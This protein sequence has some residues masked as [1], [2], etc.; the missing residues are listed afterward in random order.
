MPGY[1]HILFPTDFSKQSKAFRPFVQLVAR[2]FQAKV[3]VLHA[4]PVPSGDYGDLAG[5]LPSLTDFTTLEEKMSSLIWE[6]FSSADAAGIPEV[7]REVAF[8]D[9]TVAIGD[10]ARRCHVDLIMMT[11]HGHGR[12][13]NLLV[14]SVASKVLH[15]SECPVWTA[16][17]AEDPVTLSHLG[18]KNI[19]AALDLAPDRM[20]VIRRSAELA[21]EFGAALRLVHAIPAAEHTPG[22]PG[23]EQFPD[24]LLRT[25]RDQ[26]DK[27]QREAGTS[28]QVLVAPGGVAQAIRDAALETKAD[29]VVL[30]RGVVH[31]A[32]G[33]LLSKSYE[34]IRLSPC[35]VLSL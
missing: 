1:R 13:R 29:L 4:V 2:Q 17:H 11:T 9:P 18:I 3:T 24:Y 15:D 10:H 7:S 23:G 16:A 20:D 31:E 35:P 14:G 34:I 27:A 32:F 30:G 12:F 5:L 26:I 28:F 19:L 25:A 6:F 21:T 22:E 8:G 33:R